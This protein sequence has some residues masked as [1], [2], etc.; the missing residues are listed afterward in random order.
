MKVRDLIKI[1]YDGQK[2][3]IYDY[4]FAP[5]SFCEI[6]G[7]GEWDCEECTYYELEGNECKHLL[8]RNEKRV[9]FS[10][11]CDDVPIKLAEFRVMEIC[12]KEEGKGRRREQI[13][14]IRTAD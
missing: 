13:I 4:G 9:L 2:V 3:E 10:G 7:D 6:Y 12:V 8:E 1:I 5:F 11:Y 14:E